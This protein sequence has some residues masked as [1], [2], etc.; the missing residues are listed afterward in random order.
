VRA[1]RFNAVLHPSGHASI[2]PQVMKFVWWLLRLFPSNRRIASLT[3]PLGIALVVLTWG[4]IAILGWAMLYFAHMPDGFA[5][6]SEL[7][8]DQRND[9]FDS[10]YLSLVTSC[11]LVFRDTLPT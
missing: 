11:T 4:A 5:Y 2:A 10:L 8:P 1:A 9:L 7:N 3:G 6:S